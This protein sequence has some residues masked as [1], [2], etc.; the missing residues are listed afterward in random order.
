[1]IGE[2]PGTLVAIR[3]H[4][5]HMEG[6]SAMKILLM[7]TGSPYLTLTDGSQHRP[8]GVWAE[9]FAVP[10]ERFKERGYD[11]EVTTVGGTVP[12]FDSSSLDPEGAKW[13]RPKGTRIDDAAKC[14][15]WSRT[16]DGAPEWKTPIAVETITRDQ[17]A[18][19]DGIYL[20]GGHG[21]MEDEASSEE[22]SRVNL[23]AFELSKPVAAVCHGHCGML[24]MRDAEGKWPYRGYR[25]TSFAHDEERMTPLYGKIPFVLEEELRRLGGD[26]SKAPVIWDSYVVEDRNLITGQNPYSSLLVAETLLRQLGASRAKALAA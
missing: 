16:I 24:R 5:R 13:V 17:V 11:I 14:Q 9:E 19:Y 8:S 3:E 22:M 1:M 15:D 18:T 23:W 6:N 12:T 2:Q 4:A 26:Y 20:A 21:C 10:Y 25:V 7:M